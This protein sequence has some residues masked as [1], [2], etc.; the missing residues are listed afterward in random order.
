MPVRPTLGG[1]LPEVD[2]VGRMRGVVPGHVVHEGGVERLEI[3][4]LKHYLKLSKHNNCHSHFR[5][6]QYLP[7]KSN[8]TANSN[9]QG[10]SE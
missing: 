3:L 10:A 1:R 9:E 7:Y 2:L 5:F 6:I 8:Q 4:T